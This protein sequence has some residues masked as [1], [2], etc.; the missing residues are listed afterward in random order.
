MEDLQE[1][2]DLSAVALGVR[3]LCQLLLPAAPAAAAGQAE[4]G[5]PALG[6]WDT[7]KAGPASSPAVRVLL[8]L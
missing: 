5:E 8:A 7:T 3:R 1:Q 2:T 6:T 4:Q